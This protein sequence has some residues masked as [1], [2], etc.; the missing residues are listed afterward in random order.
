MYFPDQQQLEK[1][2]KKVKE[3]MRENAHENLSDRSASLLILEW[4]WSSEHINLMGRYCLTTTF[5]DTWGL[6]F[7]VVGAWIILPF[8]LR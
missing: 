2:T 4:G 8:L 3:E 5:K 7:Q 1:I 6:H